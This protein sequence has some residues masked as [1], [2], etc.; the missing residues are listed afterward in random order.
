MVRNRLE[1]NSTHQEESY[2]RKDGIIVA[3]IL[4]LPI[5]EIHKIADIR[6]KFA[7]GNQVDF[8]IN[9]QINGILKMLMYSRH[10]LANLN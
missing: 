6:N 9:Q 10:V 7:H 5:N 8:S 1:Y 4:K 3:N 2:L